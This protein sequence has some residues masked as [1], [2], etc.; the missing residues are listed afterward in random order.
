MHVPTP[1]RDDEARTLRWADVAVVSVV[2]AAVTLVAIA[3]G[4]AASV[5]LVVAAMVA[6]AAL[7]LVLRRSLAAT[8]TAPAWRVVALCAI[9][10]ACT[11]AAP[12]LAIV[13]AVLHPL[14]WI[15]ADRRRFGVVA[16]G[17]VAASAAAGWILHSPEDWGAALATQAGSWAFSTWF[18]LWI[19]S[20]DRL[21]EERRRLV[22]ALQASRD[23]VA[24]LASEQGAMQERDRIA[25][26]IHDT[27]AQDLAGV[28]ML[29]EGARASSDAAPAA[30]ERAEQAARRSLA[31]ARALVAGEIAIDVEGRGLAASLRDVAERFAREHGVDVDARLDAVAIDREAQVV[32]V[33]CLQ[34]ALSNVRRH[35]RA[36][37]VRV[38]LVGG[39]DAVLTVDDDGVGM[40]S[41][42]PS[43]RGFGL[44]AMARRAALAGGSASTSASPLGGTR[45]VVRVP[46]ARE[47]RS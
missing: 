18:G 15:G 33:R 9:A 13:Q 40:P 36:G 4:G 11:L 43:A 24:A 20:I 14:A 32:L 41:S 16:S 38:A 29:L 1:I 10:L 34:E 7:W 8:G 30:L 44:E 39:D 28:V 46:V 19:G 12:W 23:E 25:R 37:A 5:A 47:E 42:P 22:E 26:E 3:P 21:S 45:V 17:L 31:D 35:A 6:L 2:V 27:I